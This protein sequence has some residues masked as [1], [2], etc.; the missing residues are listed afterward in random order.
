MVKDEVLSG[1]LL[2]ELAGEGMVEADM[3]ALAKVK[4]CDLGMTMSSAGLA[5]KGIGLRKTTSPALF[6]V[7]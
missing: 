3:E 4:V 1:E 5:W 6:T 2:V 7:H